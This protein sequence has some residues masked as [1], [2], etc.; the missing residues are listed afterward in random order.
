M[1]IWITCGQKEL[2]TLIH[3][4]LEAGVS[5]PTICPVWPMEKAWVSWRLTVDIQSLNKVVLPRASENYDMNSIVQK[6]Q[7]SERD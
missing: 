3:D 6:I 4:M 1:L 7:K 2:T 5:V